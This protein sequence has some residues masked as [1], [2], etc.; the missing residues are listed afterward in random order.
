MTASGGDRPN[1]P[2]GLRRTDADKRRAV[3][4]ALGV[5]P[6]ESDDRIART[7]G[8]GA[9]MVAAVRRS[10]LGDSQGA[11]PAPGRSRE[12]RPTPNPTRP[13]SRLSSLQRQIL[14]NLHK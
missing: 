1:V 5:R 13:D 7:V 3:A 10:I 9:E 4:M 14:I 11:G 12:D 8:V 2:A 6:D